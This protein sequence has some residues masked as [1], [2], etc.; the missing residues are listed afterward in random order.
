MANFV[1]VFYL[2]LF[3]ALRGIPQ[4]VTLNVVTILNASAIPG[5]IVPNYLSQHFG[6][7]NLLIVSSLACMAIIIG[8]LGVGVG[9]GAAGGI[10]GVAVFYGFFSGG[11][12]FRCQ[13]RGTITHAY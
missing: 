4:N 2:Q 12:A 3:A 1:P 13:L 5:R 10:I 8:M 9:D 6:I 11:S 7:V